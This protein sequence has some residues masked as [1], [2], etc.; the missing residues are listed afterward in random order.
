MVAQLKLGRVTIDTDDGVLTVCRGAESRLAIVVASVVSV[1]GLLLSLCSAGMAIF[2]S[3]G[4]FLSKVGCVTFL[5]VGAIVLFL[6]YC[7]V[8]GIILSGAVFSSCMPYRAK[9]DTN[10]RTLTVRNFL[11]RVSDKPLPADC[12]FQIVR[13]TNR[14]D[15]GL[16]VLVGGKS[17]GR[18]RV[19]V[20]SAIIGDIGE[21]R[22]FAK[23][24]AD[25]LVANAAT[26]FAVDSSAW[27]A[28]K[29]SGLTS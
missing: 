14:C 25:F 26:P 4:L 15:W 29:C 18:R 6:A 9:L 13:A 19:F 8:M 5:V 27:D 21:A 16:R 17:D 2:L 10:K 11:R 3:S 7:A 1:M 12:V 22:K 28:R 20:P 24:V 23:V